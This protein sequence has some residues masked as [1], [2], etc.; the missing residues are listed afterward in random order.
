MDPLISPA[1]GFQPEHSQS[2]WTC[3]LGCLNPLYVTYAHT[4]T[5]QG[6][7]DE[8]RYKE[9]EVD[10]KVGTRGSKLVSAN[11]QT[12]PCSC[13]WPLNHRPFLVLWPPCKWGQM[14]LEFDQPLKHPWSLW[15][16]P[17]GLYFTTLP[18]PVPVLTGLTAL[19]SFATPNLMPK[20]RSESHQSPYNWSW[21][22]SEVAG[23]SN[24]LKGWE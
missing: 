24:F 10:V 6:A 5:N 12:L 11:L 14:S 18:K 15:E 1:C 3:F 7:F 20:K 19:F 4:H 22:A 9:V 2:F 23:H 21:W 8:C 17:V 16:I 13:P